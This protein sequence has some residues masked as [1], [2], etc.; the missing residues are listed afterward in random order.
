MKKI[1]IL[2]AVVILLLGSGIQNVRSTSDTTNDLALL[3]VA[4]NDETYHIIEGVPIIGQDTRFYCTMSSLTM[5]LNYYGFNL[6]KYEVF[7]L[8]GGGFSLFY[9]SE[10]YLIPFSSTGCAFRASNYEYVGS[11][12]GLTFQPFSIDLK[13]DEET[14]WEKLWQCIKE[15]VSLDQPVLVNLDSIILYADNNGIT[16]SP[17]LWS[18]VPLKAD[19]A[20]VVVGYDERNNSLCYH[21]PQYSIF[22]D[23]EN[24]SYIWIDSELFKKA[25][26]KFTRFSPYFPS[27]FRVISYKYPETATYDTMEVINIALQRNM[28]RLQGDYRYYIS[29]LDYPDSYNLTMNFTYGIN[30]SKE[31]QRIF[32]ANKQ[33]QFLTLFHY[34][35]SGKLGYKNSIIYSIEKKLLEQYGMDLSFVFDLSIPGYKNIYRTIA[36]EK[37]MISDV[38]QN[39]ALL[40]PLYQRLSELLYDESV[41]WSKIAE[42]NRVFLNK[43]LFISIPKGISMLDEMSR[44]MGDIILIQEEIL[45]YQFID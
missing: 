15:N 36:D 13:L 39:Y 40:M 7:Y 33:T 24:G 29:D 19:H 21:D 6:T 1:G 43:G 12:L 11:L 34:K 42:Y 30:A 32:G 17:Y 9:F 25:F 35:L 26:T 45:S 44:I 38:L 23:E 27:T 28:K 3:P 2:F 10:R 41:L 4:E 8:M 31:L 5:M 22:D 20:I 14:V 18:L 37:E 16:L